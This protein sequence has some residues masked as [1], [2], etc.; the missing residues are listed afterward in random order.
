MSLPRPGPHRRA[1]RPERVASRRYRHSKFG[2][3]TLVGRTDDVLRLRFDD[4]VERV[5]KE[6]FVVLVED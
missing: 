5:I 2:D 1:R 4:G 3:A 6:R